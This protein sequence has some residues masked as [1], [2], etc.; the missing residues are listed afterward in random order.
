[1]L[2]ALNAFIAYKRRNAV[3]W[4]LGALRGGAGAT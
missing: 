3:I 4:A 2:V 1:V